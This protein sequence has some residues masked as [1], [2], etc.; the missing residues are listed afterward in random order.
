MDV[1]DG[2]DGD[3]AEDVGGPR[4]DFAYAGGA[5]TVED[6]VAEVFDTAAQMRVSKKEIEREGSGGRGYFLSFSSMGL[7]PPP[8]G[9]PSASRSSYVSTNSVPSSYLT[10]P[11][12]FSFLRKHSATAEHRTRFSEG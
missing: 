12:F 9:S 2:E 3:E 4:E 5:E 11:C 1:A 7:R 6:E 10:N 8:V